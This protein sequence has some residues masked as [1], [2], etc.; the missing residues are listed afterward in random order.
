M[1]DNP[2]NGLRHAHVALHRQCTDLPRELLDDVPAPPH[3]DVRGTTHARHQIETVTM[4][5]YRR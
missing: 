2:F 4:N 3:H 5:D 1:G